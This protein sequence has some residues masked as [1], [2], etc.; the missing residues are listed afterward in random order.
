M[1]GSEARPSAAGAA[2][3]GIAGTRDRGNA[4]GGHAAPRGSRASIRSG[5]GTGSAPVLAAAGVGLKQGL[6][7]PLRS[8]SFRIDFPPG[9]R[10]PLGIA[11]PRPEA[12]AALT[13]L[14][15]GHAKPAYGELRVLGADLAT[16][17]GRVAVR[18][19]VGVA[20][21]ARRAQPALR[22]RGLVER[23]ARRAP[24]A[25]ADQRALSA[26]IIDRLELSPWA[27]VPLRSVPEGVVR[28]AR[29][30]AAAAGEPALLL[31][32]G[33]LDDLPPRDAAALAGG[34]RELARSTA[35]LVIGCDALAL[36]QVCGEVLVLADGVLGPAGAAA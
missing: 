24:V 33:L 17:A 27:G 1:A 2:G 21:R 15:S 10:P 28:R 36:W 5:R 26:A 18:S 29:L 22:V 8:A 34:L 35:I 4:R 14:L 32:D 11:V 7:W 9:G 30:A 25:L 13:D 12:G 23:A 6:G 20:R 19:R 3:A 31:A 16:P